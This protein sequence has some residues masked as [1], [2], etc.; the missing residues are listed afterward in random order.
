[1]LGIDAVAADPAKDAHE[2]FIKKAVARTIIG[3]RQ[4]LAEAID[5]CENAIPP[6]PDA[7][8]VAVW[9]AHADRMRRDALRHVIFRGEA[10]TWRDAKTRV[11]WLETIPGGPGYRIKKLR[12]EALPGLWIPALLYEPETLTGKV[13]VVLNVNGHDS[14]GKAADYKQIRCI[15]LAKRGMLALNPDWFWMGQF[16]TPDYRHDLINHIDLCA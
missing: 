12:F 6:M 4:T 8:S 15:N 9:E 3:P 7:K 5:Y 1:I 11:E 16:A 13:P 2:S 10:E 14:K